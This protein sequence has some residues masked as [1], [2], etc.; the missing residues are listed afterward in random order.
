MNNFSWNLFAV[1]IFILFMFFI[2]YF[3][4]FTVDEKALHLNNKYCFG[5]ICLKKTFNFSEILEIKSEGKFT[6]KSD[7]TEDLLSLFLPVYDFENNLFIKTNQNTEHK[8]NLY[9]YRNQLDEVVKLVNQQK[10]KA[11]V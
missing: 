5:L 9:I 8:F 3:Q 1:S 2:T 4:E 7:L 11:Q 10:Q 6:Q